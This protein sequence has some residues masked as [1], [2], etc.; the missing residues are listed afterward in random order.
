MIMKL[1]RVDH[2]YHLV[3]PSPWPLVASISLL[4][5]T[6]GA[7]SYFHYFYQG[8][9]L[10]FF[11]LFGILFSMVVW[12]RDVI[13]E[14]SFEGRHTLAVQRGLRLGVILFVVSEVLFFFSFFW[15]VFHSSLAPVA[16]IGY[17]WPPVGISLFSPWGIPFVNT[18]ILLSSGATITVAHHELVLGQRKAD[19]CNYLLFTI[20]LGF[21][22]FLL[23][24]FE[25]TS[26][27][28]HLSDG[29]FGTTFFV[30]TG[31]HALHIIVGMIFLI[32]CYF[33][34]EADQMPADHHLGFEAAALYWHFVDVV[35]LFLFCCVYWWGG[36]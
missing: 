25:Y 30:S 1:S 23:Q 27:P 8:F 29:I 22:F 24:A 17:M 34:L 15:A 10:L 5:L 4:V 28:F 35:W 36:L 20:I 19:T 31:F 14:G 26:A 21:L 12:W 32:V 13:R 18:M 7:T 33:R 9:S 2:P 6:V 3:D 11:G 16:S